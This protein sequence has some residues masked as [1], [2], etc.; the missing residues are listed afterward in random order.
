MQTAVLLFEKCSRWHCRKFFST[1]YILLM[2][3]VSLGGCTHA[4][5]PLECSYETID[6]PSQRVSYKSHFG[7]PFCGVRQWAEYVGQGPSMDRCNIRL[8]LPPLGYILSTVLLPVEAVGDLLF[9]PIDLFRKSD[10][11]EAL[12]KCQIQRDPCDVAC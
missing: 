11:N 1:N 2:V 4:L 5:A 10:R 7:A 3:F 8:D 6:T 9:L 12:D